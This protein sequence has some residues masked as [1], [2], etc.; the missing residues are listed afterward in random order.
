[1]EG[2][3]FGKENS[4]KIVLVPGNRMTW[5][6][7]AQ[8]IPRNQCRLY[9]TIR[10]RKKLPWLLKLYTRSDDASLIARFSAVPQNITLKTLENC[11]EEGL[12]LCREIDAYVPDPNAKAAVSYGVKEP[13]MKKAVQKLKRAFPA[14]E[15]H[16]FE[17]FGHGEIIAHPKRMEE[18][19]RRFISS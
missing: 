8:V 10:D 19:I 15:I 11:A 18:E 17:G 12:R 5:R 14:L 13:N 9:K 4:Q 16:P 7:F 3:K 6:Q 2:G 1:M